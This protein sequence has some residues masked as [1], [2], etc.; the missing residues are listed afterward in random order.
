MN[1]SKIIKKDRNALLNNK[2]GVFKLNFITQIDLK[3]ESR[4]KKN[5][6]DL[7]LIL[8]KEIKSLIS[9]LIKKF[10]GLNKKENSNNKKI[11]ILKRVYHKIKF[12]EE[13]NL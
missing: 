11:R 7:L 2:K 3:K 8:I 4:M 9:Y 10:L 1:N 6:R 13:K 12:I 5:L